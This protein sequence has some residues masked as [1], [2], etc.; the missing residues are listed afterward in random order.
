MQEPQ[1]TKS[2]EG[3]G[4]AALPHEH[5]ITKNAH[6]ENNLAVQQGGPELSLRLHQV[7]KQNAHAQNSNATKPCGHHQV[8]KQDKVEVVLY[9]MNPR[10]KDKL[11]ATGTLASKEKTYVVGGNMLGVQYVA[12]HVRGCT[13]LGDEKLVRPYE[14]FQTVRDAVGSVIAWPRS[15]VKIVRPTPPAQPQSIGR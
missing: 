4:S 7:T 10:N 9:S 5:V 12:V 14:K 15:H 2:K 13:Y 6:A 1:Q 11:V 3:C 8:T